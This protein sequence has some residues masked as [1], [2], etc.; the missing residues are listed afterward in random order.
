M[1]LISPA[2]KKKKKYQ[3]TLNHWEFK[4]NKLKCT[5]FKISI[6]SIWDNNIVF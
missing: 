6:P 1:I 3:M 5:N 4:E 2:V